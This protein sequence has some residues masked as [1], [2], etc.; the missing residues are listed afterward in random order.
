[1]KNNQTL[2]IKFMRKLFKFTSIIMLFIA[3]FISAQQKIDE[4]FIKENIAIMDARILSLSEKEFT[5]QLIVSNFSEEN[6][7]P[8]QLNF[9]DEEFFDDGKNNDEVAGDGIYTS[10]QTFLHSERVPYVKTEKS[11]SVLDHIII[12]KNFKKTESLEKKKK[13]ASSFGGPTATLDCD[14]K[15]VCGCMSSCCGFIVS[16]C[17]FTIGWG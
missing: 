14:I 15:W 7:L 11:Y 4:T 13:G 6:K 16:N 1:M 3:N 5:K 2:K 17:H 8:S 10:K 12:D 9:L